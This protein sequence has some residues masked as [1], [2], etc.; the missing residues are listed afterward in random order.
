MISR[1]VEKLFHLVRDFRQCLLVVPYAHRAAIVQTSI[2]FS[3]VWTHF[4]ILKLKTNVK[5]VDPAYTAWLTHIG[6]GTAKQ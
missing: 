4:K 6:N 2:K 5:S 3:N 1:L